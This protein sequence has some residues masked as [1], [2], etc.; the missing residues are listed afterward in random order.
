VLFSADPL[1]PAARVLRVWRG[2]QQ[3]GMKTHGSIREL[4]GIR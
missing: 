1:D 2:G 4:G 3:M